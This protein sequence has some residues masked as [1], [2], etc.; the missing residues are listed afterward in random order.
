MC[1][2][3]DARGEEHKNTETSRAH[4]RSIGEGDRANEENRKEQSDVK[5][6]PQKISKTRRLLCLVVHLPELC[7][8]MLGGLLRRRGGKGF[9]TLFRQERLRLCGHSSLPNGRHR[10]LRTLGCAN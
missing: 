9:E 10:P 4:P 2:K 5:R 6:A 1:V 8:R 7:E 3:E